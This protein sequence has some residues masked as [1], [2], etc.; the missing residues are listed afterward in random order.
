[1]LVISNRK[2]AYGLQRAALATPPIPTAY[3]ALQPFLKANPTKTRVDYDAEL[4]QIVLEANPDIV[5]LAGWMHVMSE[6]F[7]DILDGTRPRSE[8]SSTSCPQRIPVINLHPALPGMFDGVDA[9]R[10]AYDAFQAGQIQH[11]GVM[12]HRVVKEVDRG[13]PV[14]IREVPIHAGED[15]AALEKRVHETEWEVIVAATAMVIREDSAV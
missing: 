1:V 2:A 5:V 10:R 15:I 11:T 6:G 12:V 8:T 3:F 14:L 7:L 13:E 9:I 4:A